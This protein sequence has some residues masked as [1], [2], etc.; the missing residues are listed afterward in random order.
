MDKIFPCANS[1]V[2][3]ISRVISC[4]LFRISVKDLRLF[5]KSQLAQQDIRMGRNLRI[6]DRYVEKFQLKAVALQKPLK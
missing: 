5:P 2:P 6:N 3:D 4:Q 1:I